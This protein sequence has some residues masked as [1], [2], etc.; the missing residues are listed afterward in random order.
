[1]KR[2]SIIQSIRS[3]LPI[4]QWLPQYKREFLKWDIIAGIT[5]AT[6]I[7]P[8]S[9]AYATIA[10]VP[11]YFGIY[12]SLIG[13]LLFA[14]FTTSRHVSVGPTSSISLMVGSTVAILSGDDPQR[15]AAI[16]G[17]T[18]LVIAGICLIAF[19]LKLSSLVNFISESILLGFKAGA[20]LSIMSTQLPALFGVKGGGSN[21]F[22]RLGMFFQQYPQINWVVV[23]F[24]MV[25]LVVFIAGGKFFPGRPVSLVVVIISIILISVTQLSSYG[26]SVAGEIPQGLPAIAGPV[27]KLSDVNGVMELAFACFLMGYIETISAAQTFAIKNNYTISPR[28]ELLSLG[29][30]NLAAAFTSGYAVSGSLSKSTVNEKGG[31]KTPL[32]LIIC[33]TVLAIILLYFTGLLKN[34]PSVVLAA[35]VMYAVSGLI[36]IK[37]FKLL[38]RLDKIEFTVAVIAF[39]GVLIFGVLKGIMLAVVL[40]MALLIRRTAY[41]NVAVLGRIA[42][43]KHYSDIERHPDNITIS[44]IL[45]VRIESSI[46]YFN[47]GYIYSNIIQKTDA[48]EGD[49]KLLIMDMSASPSVDV[50][51]SKMLVELLSQLQ[52]KGVKLRVVEALSNV[53]DILRK[54][55]MEGNIGH[56]SRRVFINDAVEEYVGNDEKQNI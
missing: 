54:Q 56:I 2:V 14:I 50:S 22:E 36:K 1:M 26:I 41:P 55:G 18:A 27:I 4:T 15:W 3:H 48:Y 52:K 42:D 34:L 46:F 31:A 29:A 23:A 20:A 10:G 38:Y 35:I 11:T 33:S 6:F 51:G 53:R 37:E 28:Q 45:I 25:A 21:F 9:M 13:G 16:A 24:G 44:G 12:G 17:L 7:L 39:A 8:E 47:A 49:L 32:S 5:L 19:I 40:S 30:A 43:T